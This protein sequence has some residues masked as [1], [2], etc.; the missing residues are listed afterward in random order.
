M[1]GLVFSKAPEEFSLWGSSACL[2]TAII[3]KTE[4]KCAAKCIECHD[5]LLDILKG[6]IKILRSSRHLKIRKI[7]IMLILIQVYF[8]TSI[9]TQEWHRIQKRCPLVQRYV[10]IQY[11]RKILETNSWN[12]GCVEAWLKAWAQASNLFQILALSHTSCVTGQVT[13]PL[14]AS[15]PLSV[16]GDNHSESCEND[17]IKCSELNA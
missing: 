14:C 3:R 15:F 11:F 4:F 1:S 10:N 6:K 16:T 5:D 13:Y 2:V 8:P 12:G 17:I 7:L 9:S